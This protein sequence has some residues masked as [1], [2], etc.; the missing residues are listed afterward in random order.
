MKASVNR[1]MAEDDIREGVKGFIPQG[2]V[3]HG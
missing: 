2:L 3:G 1:R